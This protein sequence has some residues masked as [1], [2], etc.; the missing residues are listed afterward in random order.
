MSRSPLERRLSHEFRLLLLSCLVGD[1][2]AITALS[3]RLEKPAA[4][5]AYHL[6]ILGDCELVQ[7]TE[8]EGNHHAQYA[9]NLKGHPPWLAEAVMTLRGAGQDSLNFMAFASPTVGMKCDLCERLLRY[10]GDVIAIFEDETER[11]AEIVTKHLSKSKGSAGAWAIEKYHRDCY[12][13]A[14]DHDVFLPPLFG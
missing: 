13:E 9:A 11:R 3:A 7:R 10:D 4:A 8:G 6:K 2:L 5:V 1:P 14:R 12:A